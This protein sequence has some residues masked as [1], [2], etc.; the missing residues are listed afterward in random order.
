[1]DN[2]KWIIKLDPQEHVRTAT[3]KHQTGRKIT[4]TQ[5]PGKSQ[6]CLNTY[7]IMIQYNQSIFN[8]ING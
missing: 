6:K 2:N 8:V 4:G 3:Q 5:K 1:M 7:H